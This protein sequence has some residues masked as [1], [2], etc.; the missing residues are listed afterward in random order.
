MIRPRRRSAFTLIELLV[1]IA[2]IAVL[3]GLLLPAV[4]KVRE[5]A[6]RSK[7]Q[8]NLKQLA[9]AAHNYHAANG[10]LPPGYVATGTGDKLTAKAN[11]NG[12]PWVSSLALL[13][14]YLEQDAL[15]RKLNVNVN[16]DKPVGPAW[17]VNDPSFEAGLAHLNVFECP[18][19]TIY[20]AYDN[21]DCIVAL[22]SWFYFDKAQNDYFIGGFGAP[23]KV[24]TANDIPLP[25]L[26]NYLGVA[27]VEAFT[28]T[29]FDQFAGVFNAN[30]K[31]TMDGVTSADGTSNVLLFGESLGVGPRAAREWAFAWAGCGALWTNWGLFN[32]PP[33]RAS[34]F[35]SSHTGIVNFAFVD[36]SVRPLRADTVADTP[37]L[38]FQYLAGYRDGRVFDPSVILN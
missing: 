4:Q 36:G 35:S 7:C 31:V 38:A 3:I 9:L 11:P 30:S 5:A 14:P 8:N 16:L 24:F 37:W 22:F 28:G 23:V 20:S 10:A 33:S 25:G 21:P 18:S 13:L 12:A 1:V 27:G 32:D 26:T 19:D 2:I 17:Y 29:A 34:A 6:A 15:F